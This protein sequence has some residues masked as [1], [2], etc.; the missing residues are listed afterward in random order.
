MGDFHATFG[1]RQPGEET[2][3]G[4]FGYGQR[5]R[6]EEISWLNSQPNIR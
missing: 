6:R 5:N 4:K 2:K 3:C 1:E